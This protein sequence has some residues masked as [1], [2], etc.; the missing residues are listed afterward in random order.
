[1]LILDKSYLKAR[2]QYYP[3]LFNAVNGDKSS[4]KIK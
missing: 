4:E 3:R 1:M 2:N